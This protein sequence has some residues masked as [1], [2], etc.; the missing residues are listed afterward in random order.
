MWG[1]EL[2]HPT[3]GRPGGGPC[4]G[5]A[6]PSAARGLIVEL[7]GRDGCVV[8]LLPPLNVTAEIMEA[9]C[10][11]LVDCIDSW[12]RRSVSPHLGRLGI[13]G[14]CARGKEQPCAHASMFA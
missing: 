10:R 12:S 8:R 13:S 4:R 6:G 9:A 1:I 11:I 7:G 3:G 5:G 14:G 2:V